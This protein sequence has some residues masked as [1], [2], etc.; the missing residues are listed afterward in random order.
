MTQ[1][2]QFVRRKMILLKWLSYTIEW[3][4]TSKLPQH[5]V[6]KLKDYKKKIDWIIKDVLSD[7]CLSPEGAAIV[8]KDISSEQVKD[9]DLHFDF[10][11][12]FENIAEITDV[13]KQNIN[14]LTT[15]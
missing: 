13:I 7:P 2:A 11:S 6:S 12:Q 8:S 3:E 10:V 14:T 15:V 1:H 9:L 5:R 4:L